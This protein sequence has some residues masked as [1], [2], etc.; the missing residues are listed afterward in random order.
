MKKFETITEKEILTYAY[1][2]IL[3][4][5]NKE[6]DRYYNLRNDGFSI[7]DLEVLTSK[8]L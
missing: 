8:K 7:D 2:A 1:F 3:D 6:T 5:W 4:R